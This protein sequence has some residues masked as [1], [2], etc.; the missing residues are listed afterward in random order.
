MIS[1]TNNNVDYKLQPRKWSTG[2]FTVSI[3]HKL[4]PKIK[5][6]KDTIKWLLERNTL[7]NKPSIGKNSPLI[8]I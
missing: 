3:Y 4:S 7:E 2:K 8:K 5:D 1:T 6:T